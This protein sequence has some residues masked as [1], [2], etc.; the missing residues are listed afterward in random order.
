MERYKKE[1]SRKENDNVVCK[2]EEKGYETTHPIECEERKQQ[3]QRNKNGK[4]SMIENPQYVEERSQNN[5]GG[6]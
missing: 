5:V 6:L 4:K 1:A 2:I 3:E